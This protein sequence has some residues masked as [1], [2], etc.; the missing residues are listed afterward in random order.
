MISVSDCFKGT[1][2][3]GINLNQ[4]LWGGGLPLKI[5]LLRIKLHRP[6]AIADHW[7]AYMSVRESSIYLAVNLNSTQPWRAALGPVEICYSLLKGTIMQE[8]IVHISPHLILTQAAVIHYVI[9]LKIGI[10]CNY[11]I[12][13]AICFLS[14]DPAKCLQLWNVRAGLLAA[15]LIH[16]V[17]PWNNY[18]SVILA[19][20]KSTEATEKYCFNERNT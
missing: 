10:T 19:Y 8:S 12:I 20:S 18:P 17:L 15:L 2:P 3:G 11:L 7:H 4:V 14:I 6:D 16:F 13:Y 1:S 5:S 9:Q